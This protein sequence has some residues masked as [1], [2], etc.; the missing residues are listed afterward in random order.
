LLIQDKIYTYVANILIAV[1]PYSDISNLY[2]P[3]TIRKDICV[4]EF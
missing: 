3:N 2:T 1:N 4:K